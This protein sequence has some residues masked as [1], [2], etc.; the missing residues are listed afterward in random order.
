MPR[1]TAP[2]H[3]A[4][5]VCSPVPQPASRRAPFERAGVGEVEKRGLRAADVPGRRLAR[6]GVVPVVGSAGCGHVS[7]LAQLGKRGGASIRRSGAPLQTFPDATCK[8]E[9]VHSQPEA[10]NR[11][12]VP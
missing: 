5:I 10:P 12:K 11:K 9:V 4:R 8:D 7:I 6:V 1:A 2:R 3:T